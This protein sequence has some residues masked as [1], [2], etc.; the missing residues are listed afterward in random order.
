M[1]RLDS[2]AFGPLLHGT[3]RAWR[4]KLDA[5]LKPMGLSQAKWRTLLHLSL[6]DA[7]LT[8]AEVASRL[9]IEEPTLVN[10]LHRLEK[11]GWVTRRN[12][13]H[14][15][16]CKTVHLGKRAYGIISQ[17]NAAAAKLR[18]ELLADI[19]VSE[20]QTCMRVIAQIRDKAERDDRV[21][22]RKTGRPERNGPN[23]D[24]HGHPAIK[25][26]A[27]RRVAR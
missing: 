5:R 27:S 18:K 11:D 15:R 2:E 19:P 21:S 1:S 23:G 9:G 13:S 17:I 3:A 14:D 25:L 20:L 4:L 12:A 7:T 24:G 26:R 6:A 22:G 16:R 10:L 8:Q